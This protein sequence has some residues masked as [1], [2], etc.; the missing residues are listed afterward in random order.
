[1]PNN[2]V[3]PI[4]L[5]VLGALAVLFIVF[6]LAFF[7][8]FRPWLKGFLAG[9]PISLF[10]LI[11]M[12]LRRSNVNLI[13]DQGI[14]VAQAGHRISWPD[15]ERAY[16]QKVDLEKMTL[17]YISSQKQNLGFTFRELVEAELEGNLA[18]FMQKP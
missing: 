6:L 12:R 1:M 10:N 8:F 4:F 16:L 5:F 18:K 2:G 7:S 3:S 15:L 13:L 14:A 11:G 17:A 9:T